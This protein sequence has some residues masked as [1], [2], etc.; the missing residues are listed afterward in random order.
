M[1]N[2]QLVKAM[3]KAGLCRHFVKNP[4]VVRERLASPVA[5]DSIF[6]HFCRKEW[7]VYDLVDISFRRIK[8]RRA[9]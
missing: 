5:L 8:W 7:A 9:S 6:C 3:R 1:N 4:G 2:T